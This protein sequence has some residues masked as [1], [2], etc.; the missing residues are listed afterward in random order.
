VQRVCLIR[1]SVDVVIPDRRTAPTTGRVAV[2]ATAPAGTAQN[3]VASVTPG[4]IASQLFMQVG[5]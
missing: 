4:E 2:T 1:L 3:S 5:L